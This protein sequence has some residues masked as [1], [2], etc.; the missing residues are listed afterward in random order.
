[1]NN[2]RLTWMFKQEFLEALYLDHKI[3]LTSNPKFFTDDTSIFSAVTDPNAWVNQTSNNVHNINTLAS[4]W[5]INFNPDTSKQA[6]EVIFSLKIKVTYCSSSTCF[7][8]KS[9]T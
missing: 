6:Q 9:S 8:Q 2:A 4:Q 3:I 1:M 7:Q 5:K